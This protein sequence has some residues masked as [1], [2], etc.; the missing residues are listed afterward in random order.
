MTIQKVIDDPDGIHLSKGDGI[1]IIDADSMI[2]ICMGAPTLRACKLKLDT[3]ILNSMESTNCSSYIGCLSVS[4]TFRVKIGKTKAYKGNRTEKTLPN[5]FYP[6]KEYAQEAWGFF[7]APGLEADDL[8]CAYAE[9]Y[10]PTAM[11]LSIDKDV[12][13]QYPGTH[14]NYLSLIHI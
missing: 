1:A 12:L 4:D 14:Y 13:Q 3:L 7:S 8:V 6:L 9:K 2:Y 10:D 11:V 5:T